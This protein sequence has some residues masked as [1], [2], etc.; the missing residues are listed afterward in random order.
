M[1]KLFILFFLQNLIL[2]SQPHS[3]LGFRGM[4]FTPTAAE[5]PND[6]ET[7]FGYSR[8]SAPYNFI[9]KIGKTKYK[10]SL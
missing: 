2:A 5:F 8:I 6:G 9:D 1:K 4:I 3:I 10:K 7:G